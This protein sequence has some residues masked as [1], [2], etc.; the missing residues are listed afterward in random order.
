MIENN[1]TNPNKQQIA[2][3]IKRKT[4]ECMFHSSYYLFV[5]TKKEPASVS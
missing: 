1:A 3:T 4:A 5:L 2:Q